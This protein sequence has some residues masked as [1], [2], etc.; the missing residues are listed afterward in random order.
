MGCTDSKPAPQPAARPAAARPA[1]P[2]AA[3][4]AAPVGAAPVEEADPPKSLADDRGGVEAAPEAPAASPSN[5]SAQSPKM[6]EET[7]REVARGSPGSPSG[8]AS[9]EPMSGRQLSEDVSPGRSRASISE[10]ARAYSCADSSVYSPAPPTPQR[11]ELMVKGRT[12]LYGHP[13]S[14]PTVSVLWFMRYNRID[15]HHQEVDLMAG[16]QLSDDFRV[17]NEGAAVPVLQDGFLSL[18]QAPAIL[19]HLRRKPKASGGMTF[20]NEEEFNFTPDGEPLSKRYL[21]RVDEYIGRHHT[22]VRQLSTH[23]LAPLVYA[24]RHHR[25]QVYY[26]VMEGLLPIFTL[27]EG[28]LSDGRHYVLGPYLSICDFLLVPEVDL[29]DRLRMTAAF[30]RLHDYVSRMRTVDGYDHAAADAL[31]IFDALGVEG[32]IFK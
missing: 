13:F 26:E 27:L 31:K 16:E 1:P 14:A 25:Y 10:S 2:A 9:A 5:S 3:A 19:K 24:P 12:V 7:Q 22:V 4:P 23:G 32:D 29:L 28:M 30:P 20:L 17:R 8:S 6:T 18:A 21:A 11:P 15:V